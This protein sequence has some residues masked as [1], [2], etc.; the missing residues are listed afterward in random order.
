VLL[1]GDFLNVNGVVH[2]YVAVEFFPAG[3]VFFGGQV[4]FLMELA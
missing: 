1:L 4:L 3:F 2:D